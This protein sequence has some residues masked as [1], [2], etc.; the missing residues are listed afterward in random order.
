MVEI[1]IG[2]IVDADALRAAVTDRT[3]AIA[4]EIVQG[5]CGVYPLDNSFVQLARELADQHGALL[6][7]DEIQ[8]G[9]GR[10]GRLFAC[11]HAG[12]APLIVLNKNDLPQAAAA[13]D[14]LAVY[15][16]LGYRVE[17]I[18][19]RHDIAPLAALL[20]GHTSVLVGQSGMGK[21][22]L[23]NKLVP[24]AMMRVAETSAALDS[25]K[26]TTTGA[27]LL[28]IDSRSHLIDS[29]GLQSFGLHHLSAVDLVHA[30]IE[31]RPWLS[32][33]RFRD[34]T[35]R[36]EPDC[37]I[38]RAHADG[39]IA[40]IDKA[41]KPATSAEDMAAKLG[42]SRMLRENSGGGEGDLAQLQNNQNVLADLAL[43]AEAALTLTMRIGRALDNRADRH[44]ELLMRFA[45]AA[46]KYWICKRGP[47]VGAGLV[48]GVLA[49]VSIASRNARIIDGHT[50]L[51]VAAGAFGAFACS[52]FIRRMISD[53]M[54]RAMLA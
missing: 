26:H 1:V 24:E 45:T 6:I 34:C 39:R 28:H 49:D 47:A 5:E 16:A 48:A 2:E 46:G 52:A 33:C 35:H 15:R 31:F 23:V 32:Q 38:S 25:G 42:L 13:W 29:P 37:A 54:S 17:R 18:S 19:A 21:S 30:F 9:M 50:R 10:T 44:E 43:E 27:R 20:D 36:G 4:I 12:I 3:C 22:T 51:G 53:V 11:E 14:A 40:A 41:V 8:T 7:V